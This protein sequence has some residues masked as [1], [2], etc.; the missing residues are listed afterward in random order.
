MQL[1]VMA[2]STATSMDNVVTMAKSLPTTAMSMENALPRTGSW[3]MALGVAAL[4]QVSGSICTA[5]M[6]LEFSHICATQASGLG[7][8]SPR[9]CCMC[10][11]NG[12]LGHKCMKVSCI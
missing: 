9:V 7:A 6:V 10:L 8:V 11:E 3:N 12:Y 4:H 5:H 1:T 2:G